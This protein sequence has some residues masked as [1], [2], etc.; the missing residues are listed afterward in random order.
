VNR[1]R[2]GGNA[3]EMLLFNDLIHHLDLVE[4]QFQSRSFTW[5]N[6]QDN[7]LLKK[8]DL[9]LHLNL[10]DLIISRY[11]NYSS[12][13]ANLTPYVVQIFRFENYWINF[14][15]FLDTVNLHWHSTPFFANSAKT[16]SGKFKQVRRGLKAW[17]HNLSNLNKNNHNS[18]WV[19]ALL[20]GLEDARPRCILEKKSDRL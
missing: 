1:S 9:G 18:S 6:M 3:N 19:L 17:S 5:S 11:K 20:D 2:C 16:L 10:M 4:I 13:Q 15:G 8:L 14:E 12:I 7:A